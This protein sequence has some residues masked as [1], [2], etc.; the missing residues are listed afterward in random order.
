MKPNK[1][2][3]QKSSWG[4]SRLQFTVLGDAQQRSKQQGEGGRARGRASQKRLE[5]VR[6]GRKASDVATKHRS[7]WKRAVNGD[8]RRGNRDQQ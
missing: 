5:G 8:K 7:M 6:R 2:G 1:K 4:V 3:S